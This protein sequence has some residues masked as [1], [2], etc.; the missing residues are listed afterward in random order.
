MWMCLIFYLIGVKSS[1]KWCKICSLIGHIYVHIKK[2]CIFFFFIFSVTGLCL[3][4]PIKNKK[5]DKENKSLKK[6]VI[7]CIISYS[8]GDWVHVCYLLLYGNPTF[9]KCFLWFLVYVLRQTF[10]LLKFFKLFQ[11]PVAETT[12]GASEV[13]FQVSKDTLGAVL[14]SMAYIREQLL[15]PVSCFLLPK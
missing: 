8:M 5:K 10:R 15:G 9:W 14:R 4:L 12:S 2:V 3:P 7:N 1:W 6:N 13:K 11:L